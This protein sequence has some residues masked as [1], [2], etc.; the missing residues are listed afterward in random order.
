MIAL[1]ASAAVSLTGIAA[2]ARF[3]RRRLAAEPADRAPA[4]PET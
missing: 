4:A 2:I 1:V 3:H